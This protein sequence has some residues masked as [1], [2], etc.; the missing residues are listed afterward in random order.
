MTEV[1]TKRLD[2]SRRNFAYTFLAKISVK[3]VNEQNKLHKPF[4]RFKEQYVFNGLLFM[5][6][7]SQEQKLVKNHTITMFLDIYSHDF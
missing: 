2:R 4:Q 1:A 7:S 3:F 5:K 6:Y